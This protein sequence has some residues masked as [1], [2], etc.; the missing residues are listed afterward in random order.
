[1]NDRPSP[2]PDD[3]RSLIEADR[4]A[5][6]IS[7]ESRD[8]IMKRMG[9]GFL[10]AGI[11]TVAVT[12]TAKAAASGTAVGLLGR[13]FASKT[14]LAATAFVIGGAAGASG[15]AVA[16]RAAPQSPPAVTAAAPTPASTS[17]TATPAPTTLPAAPMDT[18]ASPVPVVPPVATTVP[19]TA[20]LA[21]A[22]APASAH[23]D[24]LQNERV[25]VEM[26]RS[27]LARGQPA[28]ALDAANRHAAKFPGGQLAEERESIAI[29]ALAAAGRKV[30]ARLRGEAFKKRYPKSIFLPGVET[31]MGSAP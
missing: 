26:A 15:Y 17:H 1:M 28:Q 2:L 27:A 19:P 18:S 25:L 24:D 9:A 12:G 20:A 13:F 23:D 31:V 21:P 14:A 4:R 10:A 16:T 22:K 29:H 11:T 3:I 8:R 7:D 5:T 30:E 6:S